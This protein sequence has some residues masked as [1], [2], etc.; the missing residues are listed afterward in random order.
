MKETN[1][2]VFTVVVWGDSIAAGNAQYQWPALAELKCN[3][4]LNTGKRIKII[5]EGVGGMAA[6]HALREFDMRV[7]KHLPNLVIIQFG[8]NDIRFDGSRIGKPISTVE[9]FEN[10]LSTMIHLCREQ[11]KASP[12]LLGNHKTRLQLTLPSGIEYDHARI[13]YNNAAHRVAHKN[14]VPFFDME[15][16]LKVP[17]AHWTNFVCEDGVHL[18]PLGYHAY[19]SRISC[20]ITE[21]VLKQKHL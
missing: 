11:A 13:Q 5:N 12:I 17:E 20:I 18:S 15:K 7:K 16:E 2:N 4:V 19:A 6:A 8:F 3:L 1:N 21:L 10:H 9:E 14:N